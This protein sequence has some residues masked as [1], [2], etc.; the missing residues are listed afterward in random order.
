MGFVSRLLHINDQIGT[1]AA[2][3]AIF[4]AIGTFLVVLLRYIWGIGAI[5][6][7]ET[8]MYAFATLWW[9]G[10]PLTFTHDSHVRVDIFYRKCS[11]RAQ[12][13]INTLGHCLFLL[14]TCTLLIYLSW[15]YV[16][17]SW[18]L[19]ETS[20]EPGGLPLLFL[21]KSLLLIG[22]CLLAIHVLAT[23]IKQLQ[24]KN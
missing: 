23:V 2:V 6:L 17:T 11:A 12:R 14:P 15:P 9:L 21:L 4:M 1:S 19:Q 22:P 8:V 24:Q 16:I 5:G 3:L 20:T 13:F 10:A 18:S 7:Q